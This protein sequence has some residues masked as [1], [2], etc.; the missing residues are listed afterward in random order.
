M[1]ALEKPPLPP[2]DGALRRKNAQAILLQNLKSLARNSVHEWPLYN[3]VGDPEVCWYDGDPGSF[4]SQCTKAPEL[5]NF[6]DAHGSVLSLLQPK[7]EFFVC[8]S[9]SS[10]VV[11][12]TPVIFSDYVLSEKMVELAKLR[13]TADATTVTQPASSLGTN[14]GIKSF[15][16]TYDNKSTGHYVVKA[17]MEMY[18]GSILELLNKNYLDFIFTTGVPSM[19]GNMRAKINESSLGERI[20]AL[21]SDLEA[22][23]Q[24]MRRGG[25]NPVLN[26]EVL[27][28]TKK[29]KVVCGWSVPDTQIDSLSEDM[30][31]A[32]GLTQRT[33]YLGLYKYELDFLEEGQVS[34]TLHFNSSLDATMQSKRANT[35]EGA[36][37]E[38]DAGKRAVV[39]VPYGAGIKQQGGWQAI[40]RDLKAM[41]SGYGP[42]FYPDGYI[43]SRRQA[44]IDDSI[45]IADIGGRDTSINIGASSHSGGQGPTLFSCYLATEEG[46]RYEI[47]WLEDKIELLNSQ[48]QQS[49]GDIN[50]SETFELG[51]DLEDV[52][53]SQLIKLYSKWLES[54]IGVQA[55]IQTALRAERYA[56]F[57]GELISSKR[58]FE[59]SVKYENLAHQAAGLTT[60]REARVY[61]G[62]YY[63]DDYE[64]SFR[65]DGR[66]R[67]ATN[68]DIADASVTRN[69]QRRLNVIAR[70][71][72]YK[73]DNETAADFVERKGYLDLA[74][75]KTDPKAAVNVPY[76]RL[77]D[78]ISISLRNTGLFE[79][80]DVKYKIMLGSVDVA[81]MGFS[82][83]YPVNQAHDL[84][85]AD[86]PISLDYYG[87]WFVDNIISAQIGVYPVR[88]FL[89]D[90]LTGLVEPMLNDLIPDVT[91]P[92]SM[93]FTV[94]SYNVESFAECLEKIGPAALIVGPRIHRPQL[95]GKAIADPIYGRTVDVIV[96]YARQISEFRSGNKFVD[97]LD[98]I[99]HFYVGADRG[100]QKSFSFSEQAIPFIRAQNIVNANSASQKNVLILPQNVDITMVGNTFFP[101]G[102]VIFV[103]AELGLG[104]EAANTLGLGGYY[105]VVKSVNSIEPGAFNTT[106]TCIRLAGMVGSTYTRGAG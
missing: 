99:F 40:K 21:E 52:P 89:N 102:S 51:E 20:S 37:K 29:L 17:T 22:R 9:D 19:A 73:K 41:W 68:Q 45:Y 106:L 97:E 61:A 54:A 11:T 85:L 28:E 105:S 53:I 42:S 63:P 8:D 93:G 30:L 34:L 66:D 18:F 62:K 83:S 71:E 55:Y 58:I 33:M 78:L 84:S 25:L 103:N 57:L 96:I 47:K 69:L 94:G 75:P 3:T 43:S 23:A 15:Q 1:S 5:K 49:D 26:A 81:A 36:A 6:I 32:I 95:L 16:W 7:L 86:L 72:I 2:V 38:A 10:G 12:E 4:V 13:G 24:F 90:L 70:A 60:F 76:M 65:G 39:Q 74:G 79:A 91:N 87:Q 100:I 92:V 104:K 98:G 14:V 77:G 67:F 80:E 50:M 46:V 64:F 101:N 56:S 27:E 48:Y 82:D 31:T 88:Q 35:L 44:N 59:A